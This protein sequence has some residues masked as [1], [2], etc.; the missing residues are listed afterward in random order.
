MASNS[1]PMTRIFSWILLGFL[2]LGLAGFGAAN[3]GGSVQSIG[4]VGDRDIPV[5]TY[6]RALQNELRATEAQFG[7][8]LSMQQAQAFGITNRVLSRVVIETALDSEAERIAL[9]VDDAAVAKDLNNIQAFKGPDGQFSREN[10][11]FSLK[12]A[13]YSETEFEESVRTESARTIL[14]AAIIAGNTMPSTAIDTVLDYL[15]ETR[16]ITLTTLT[17]DDL[18]QTIAD[19]DLAALETYYKDNIATYTLPE[20]KQI[21]YAILTP[22]MVLDQVDLPDDALRAAY[23]A[24]RDEF[25]QPERRLVERLV[26]LDAD[27]AHA[28]LAEI[29]A[30]TTDFET[31]VADRGL[32]L[33]DI[34]I[35]DVTMSE[36]GEASAGVFAANLDQVVGPFDT[37]LGPALFRVNG[38][39][40]ADVVTFDE[41]RDQLF[42]ELAT[43]S[44]RRMID[45]KSTEID[46]AMAAGATLED[47]EKEFG[48]RVDVLMYHDGTDAEVAG[49]PNFRAV[50][51]AVQDGDFP[52]VEPLNDG[53]IFSLRLDGIEPPAPMPL[54]EVMDQVSADWRT[55]QTRAALEAFAN[56]AIA[57]GA[58]AGSSTSLRDLKR[59]DVGA[60]ATAEI[61]AAAFK[62]SVGD[63]TVLM[64]NDNAVI[65]QLDAINKGDRDSDDTKALRANIE[66]QFGAS[67]ADD[68]FNVFATQIQ[69]SAGISLNQQ[70]INAVHANFQ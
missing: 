31:V 70:A 14:Q 61:L 35:G 38:I 64:Q 1:K 49:Y 53:G 28:T 62:Q 68:L 20:R 16:N 3:L 40:V 66:K 34:D 48:M 5:T 39:L 6:A 54:D 17:A 47:L 56:D 43:E 29:D 55:A 9:S 8:Q 67:L 63:K 65:V 30:G 41:A 59:T 19:P 36:L 15:T 46:D 50:A 11:R 60:V 69:Q 33:A 58:V 26:F 4:A 24:R 37:D 51:S 2:F 12:N 23:D 18:T 27:Q 44:A 45:A 21:T 13:G 25:N 42:D 57:S 22:D 32:A 52:T 7:Q 10:Y